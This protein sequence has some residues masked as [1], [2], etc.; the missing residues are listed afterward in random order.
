MLADRV[1]QKVAV[2]VAF[3]MA[4]F[5]SI[6]DVTI[7]NVALPTVAGDFGVIPSQTGTVNVGFLVALAV[8]IPASGWL[9]DRFGTK[10]VFMLALT[11]FTIASALCASAQSL[12]QL[13]AF[14][15]LQG[16]GG[17]MLTP[18]GMAMLFR[19]FPPDERVR[20][21]RI[22]ILPT[23]VAPALGPVLGGLLVQHAS[24]RWVFLVNLP[25]GAIALAF[26]WLFVAEHKEPD[27]GRFDIA[28]FLLAGT[29]FAAVMYAL[30]AGASRGWTS[31]QVW[32]SA[33]VG[34]VL[35]AV[36]IAVELQL[37]RP[38]LHLRLYTEPLFRS[39]I[40]VATLA[41]A[42][43]LGL[44]FLYPL[45]LQDGFGFSPLKT[46]L[47]TFPEALGVMVGSQV[48]GRLYAR[49]GP[50]RL[51]VF[52]Q[53]TVM[54]TNLALMASLSPGQA[55]VVPVTLMFV[56]GFG[57]SH[58]FVSMQAV[59][60]NQISRAETGQ[61]STIFNAQRQL[62]AAVGVAVVGTVLGTVGTTTAAGAVDLHAYRI[63]FIAAA[64]WSLLAAIAASQVRPGAPTRPEPAATVT[65][66]ASPDEA[67]SAI[68]D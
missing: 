27:A 41:P 18:V 31:P 30:S 49:F 36:M 16:I 46:G 42:G 21:S 65:G 26:A 20:A 55:L 33:V 62:G 6:L 5:V 54:A 53:L 10:R 38:M 51:M 3:V 61:A 56:L 7:I 35:L 66:P 29:G 32:V 25:I 34:G 1:S 63:G 47:L 57:M 11:V 23:A 37:R 40:V 48:A 15:I 8:F 12:E 59:A 68:G 19:A 4:M 43:F 45:F 14:R 17:G 44:L 13:V 24:W 50:R 22:L 28:G 39:S 67:L 2:S 52:G 58:T 64:V 60:F 9:G